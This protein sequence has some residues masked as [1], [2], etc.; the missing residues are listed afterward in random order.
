MKF[1]SIDHGPNRQPN[2]MFHVPEKIFKREQ[3]KM[4]IFRRTLFKFKASGKHGIVSKL[5]DK[6]RRI[7]FSSIDDLIRQMS[8]F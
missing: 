2:K 5:E 8:K 7:P 4:S 1:H 3:I 6:S